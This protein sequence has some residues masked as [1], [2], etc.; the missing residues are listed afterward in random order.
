MSWFQLGLLTAFGIF[1]AIA[2]LI[3]SGILPGFKSTSGTAAGE[4]VMWGTLSSN[5][6]S[7]VEG[8]VNT[9]NNQFKLIYVQK[10]A[11]NFE[12]LL[13]EALASGNGPDLILAP[14]EMIIRQQNKIQPIPYET[15]SQRVFQ[16]T[17][18]DGAKIF[19]TTNGFLALPAYVDPLVYYFN[20]DL[21]TNAGIINYPKK[22]EEIVKEQPALTKVDSRNNILQ[23]SVAFG[24]FSNITNAKDILAMLIMQ[25]GNPIVYDAG[26]FKR[27]VSLS[28]SF[29]YSPSPAVAATDFF[30]QFSNPSKVTYSWNRALP[31]ARDVFIGGK[32]ANYF[33]LAS[34]L[35]TIKGQN[36]HLNFD[37]ALIPQQSGDSRLTFGRFYGVAV[38]RTSKK[39][40][41]AMG[42]STVLAGKA[43]AQVMV[44]SFGVVPVRRDILATG[45]ADPFRT[46]FYN[47]ALISRAW[48]DVN[49]TETSNIFRRMLDA[50][51][52]GQSTTNEAIR[53]AEEELKRL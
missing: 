42:A 43:P 28:E 16:D 52:A 1:L 39:L 4:V 34:E 38:L 8:N 15:V 36:P 14:H 30:L 32:L 46:V 29:G 13:I 48:Y 41:T 10:P 11:E 18:V 7:A 23:S 33:G 2:M 50:I 31:E 45:I 25:A 44:D 24:S 37:T 51:I 40:A 35:D 26:D 22:W 3:F 19:A 21:Y 9:N 12:N 27:R 49:Q 6:M 53:L 17:F 20:K 47:S 5:F